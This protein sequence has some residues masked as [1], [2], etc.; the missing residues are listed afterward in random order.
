LALL[1]GPPENRL[2]CQARVRGVP[3]LIRLRP[4]GS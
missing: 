4:I 1:Q 3:G 2:A